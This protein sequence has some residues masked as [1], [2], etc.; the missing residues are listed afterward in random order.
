MRVYSVA[1]KL[2]PKSDEKMID[3]PAPSK[4]DAWSKAWYNTIPKKEGAYPSEIR[5][6][7][8]RYTNGKVVML[9]QAA[10]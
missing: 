1:Y 4:E 7:S 10:T 6:V 2:D 3:V 5:I 9:A 8:V